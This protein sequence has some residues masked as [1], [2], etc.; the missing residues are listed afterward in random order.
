[1]LSD[2]NLKAFQ[3]LSS[4][5]TLSGKFNYWLEDSNVTYSGLRL[6]EWEQ[7][8]LGN[9]FG[10]RVRRLSVCLRVCDGAADVR[11]GGGHRSCFSTSPPESRNWLTAA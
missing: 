9:P 11:A 7:N 2:F 4:R 3:P 6:N 10:S 5:H 8:P 1:G